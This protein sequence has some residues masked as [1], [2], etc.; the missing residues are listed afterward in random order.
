MRRLVVALAL[1]LAASPAFAFSNSFRVAS[2]DTTTATCAAK[3]QVSIGATVMECSTSGGFVVL[4]TT[5]PSE[6]TNFII[7]PQLNFTNPTNGATGNVCTQV[8]AWIVRNDLTT[9]GGGDLSII[10]SSPA[11]ALA[12]SD[13][14]A[15][16]WHL[17]RDTFAGNLTVQD[18]VGSSC[19][20]QT[21]AGGELY[22]AIV[23]QVCAGNSTA[24]VDYLSL[25]VNYQ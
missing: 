18:N 2:A 7:Q 14:V 20:T 8:C 23:R 17:I 22:I 5:W 12:S 11:C 16:Q 4:H 24:A 21:C 3:Y 6:A 10:P 19:S 1:I 25:V 13:A 9:S 15:G